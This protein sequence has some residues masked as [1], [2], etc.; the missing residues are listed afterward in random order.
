MY[1]FSEE[2]NMGIVAELAHSK[3]CKTWLTTMD[4]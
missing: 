1:L 2:E 4:C 3:M